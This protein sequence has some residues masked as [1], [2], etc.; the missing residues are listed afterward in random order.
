MGRTA[1][2]TRPKFRKKEAGKYA[3]Q[4]NASRQAVQ[5]LKEERAKKRQ[6]S[7]EE[8][9]KHSVKQKMQTTKT[10]SPKVVG[11]RKSDVK[12][13]RNDIENSEQY[14]SKKEKRL[15]ARRKVDI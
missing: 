6:K 10:S 7:F 14:K 2:P 13:F 1:T 4:K 9:Q 15:E 11:R 8:K 5:R 12:S 3:G